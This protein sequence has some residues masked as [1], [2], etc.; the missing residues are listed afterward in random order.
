GQINLFRLVI[1]PSS[2]GQSV[3]NIYYL[4]FLIHDGICGLDYT[5]DQEPVIFPVQ[6]SQNGQRDEGFQRHQLVLEFDMATWRRAIDV[7]SIT[8][9]VIPHRM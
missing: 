1:N 7:F 2:F 5:D 9:S 8:R 3:E 6:R 4:T